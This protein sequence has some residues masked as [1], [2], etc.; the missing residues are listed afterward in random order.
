MQLVTSG[1]IVVSVTVESK[2]I[3]CIVDTEQE[4][5]STEV[6]P[7]GELLVGNIFLIKD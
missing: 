5:T 2:T 7:N 4:I 1:E 6:L 3:N